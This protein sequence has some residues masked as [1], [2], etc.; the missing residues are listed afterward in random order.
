VNA[1]IAQVS[2]HAPLQL[3]HEGLPAVMRKKTIRLEIDEVI[4]VQRRKKTPYPRCK[5][6]GDEARMVTLD[7][8]AE[9]VDSTAR[10]VMGLI[11]EGKVHFA[12]ISGG[13]LFVCVNSLRE[14][15]GF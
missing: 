1:E 12:Q 13:I 2:P 5:D 10:E 15:G 9:L 4:V 14:S 11:G 8:A 3:R 7:E 6:C